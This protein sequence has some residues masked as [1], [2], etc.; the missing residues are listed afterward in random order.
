MDYEKLIE[1]LD[2]KDKDIARRQRMT[3]SDMFEYFS[4]LERD[5][6]HDLKGKAYAFLQKKQMREWN[7]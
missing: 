4:G 6:I 7:I 5:R 3:D 1:R 2:A